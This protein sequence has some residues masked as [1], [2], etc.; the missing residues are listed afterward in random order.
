MIRLDRYDIAILFEMYGYAPTCTELWLNFYHSYRLK[1]GG[2]IAKSRY[3]RRL[4]RLSRHGL[5]ACDLPGMHPGQPRCWSL[6]PEGEKI[7]ER[8][9]E[10]FWD[11]P[12]YVY[13]YQ[14]S[15]P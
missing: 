11:K 15:K 12:G 7:V 13:E 6:S 2:C 3:R 8:A 4:Y 5:C 14:K 10:V 1:P 9:D